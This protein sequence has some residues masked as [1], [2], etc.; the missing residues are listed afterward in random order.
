VTAA[1]A[2]AL[3]EANTVDFR[4]YA[5]QTVR[6]SQTLSEE[7]TKR[8]FHLISGGSDNHLIL[9]DI[10][11]KAW[12][13]VRSKGFGSCRNCCK[14]KHHTI[15]KEICILS[16]RT[17]IGY[18]SINYTGHERTEMR[19]IA[20]LMDITKTRQKSMLIQAWIQKIRILHVKQ[21]LCLRSRSKR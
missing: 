12:T 2:V 3:K 20:E 14:Q 7:L 17:K 16:F 18:S 15:R 21:E 6:N 9:I 19:K 1:V 5:N 13:V 10:L 11:I 8:G 4:K